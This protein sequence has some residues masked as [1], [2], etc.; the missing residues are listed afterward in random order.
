MAV[1]RRF[2]MRTILEKI[3][4][5]LINPNTDLDFLQTV[6][7]GDIDLMPTPKTLEH[8]D[9]ALKYLPAVYIKPSDIYNTTVNQNKSI[10]SGQYCVTLRYV[11]YYDNEDTANAIQNAISGA[12]VI[13]DTLLEDHNFENQALTNAPQYISLKDDD[14]TEIGDILQTE[15]TKI[16]FDTLE[17][18]FFKELSL[19]VIVI[20]I[21][22]IVFFR[23]RFRR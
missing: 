22:Y 7:I 6:A 11:H 15:L 16:S 12:E 8:R 4:A 9:T 19:P 3:K 23:S 17:T 2:F 5:D 1:R 21:D 10:S 14:G 20:D 13:A 18:E